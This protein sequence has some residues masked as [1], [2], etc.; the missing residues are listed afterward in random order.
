MSERTGGIELIQ[1][2]GKG[3]DPYGARLILVHAEDAIRGNA[4]AVFRIVT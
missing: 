4:F 2:V 1:P 3:T